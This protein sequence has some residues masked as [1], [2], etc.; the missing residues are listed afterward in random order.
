M[1]CCRKTEASEKRSKDGG[2]EMG[3]KLEAEL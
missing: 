1:D 3:E 2:K